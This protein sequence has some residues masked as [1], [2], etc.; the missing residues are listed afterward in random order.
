MSRIQKSFNLERAQRWLKEEGHNLKSV[1]VKGGQE[2]PRRH[3]SIV[4]AKVGRKWLTVRKSAETLGEAVKSA[5]ETLLQRAEKVRQRS[6]RKWRD[7]K[8]NKLSGMHQLE[9]Y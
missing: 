8:G 9:Y 4:R 5:C 3:Y 1:V 2:G 7:S 6:V